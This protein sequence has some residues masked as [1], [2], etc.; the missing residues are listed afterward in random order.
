MKT[1]SSSQTKII[2][3]LSTCEKNKTLNKNTV[4][5]KKLKKSKKSFTNFSEEMNGPKNTSG[6]ISTAEDAPSSYSHRK[7][8]RPRR[9]AAIIANDNLIA[10]QADDVLQSS[11]GH[12]GKRTAGF[13]SSPIYAVK[14]KKKRKKGA[15]EDPKDEQ[16]SANYPASHR[17]KR[18]S[19]GTKTSSSEAKFSVA[20]RAGNVSTSRR[21]A[22][23]HFSNQVS[24]L[25]LY[26]LDENTDGFVSVAR[27]RS[28]TVKKKDQSQTIPMLNGDK[29]RKSNI[30]LSLSPSSDKEEFSPVQAFTQNENSNNDLNDWKER[31]KRAWDNLLIIFRQTSLS[32]NE[33]KE[34]PAT[35][36]SSPPPEAN[37]I[38]SILHEISQVD[39]HGLQWA[40]RFG[41]LLSYRANH[42]HAEV[43]RDYRGRLGSW[44]HCQRNHRESMDNKR[45]I[46]LDAIG[47]RWFGETNELDASITVMDPCYAEVSAAANVIKPPKAEGS[48]LGFK[49]DRKKIRKALT[50]L[51]KE[52]RGA[53]SPAGLLA[54]NTKWEEKY[55]ILHDYVAEH[56]H[57]YVPLREPAG[58]LGQWVADQRRSMAS[59]AGKSKCKERRSPLTPARILAL[60]SLGFWWGRMVD[61]NDVKLVL[62]QLSTHRKRK[63]GWEDIT[64]GV[65]EDAIKVAMEDLKLEATENGNV[66]NGEMGFHSR[67]VA[68]FHQ[69]LEFLREH[70]HTLVPGKHPGGLGQWVSDQRKYIATAARYKGDISGLKTPLTPAR[71]GALGAAKFWWGM[72]VDADDVDAVLEML[73]KRGRFRGKC[74]EEKCDY[75]PEDL[76]TALANLRGDTEKKEGRRGVSNYNAGKWE[77]KFQLLVKYVHLHNHTHVPGRYPGGLGQWA[78]DQ[79]KFMVTLVALERKRSKLKSPL[80]LLR[81]KT[82]EAIKFWWGMSVAAKDV[83]RVIEGLQKCAPDK[84]DS[85]ENVTTC[86]IGESEAEVGPTPLH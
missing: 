78:A 84:L 58:G 21:S 60:E 19:K 30:L 45:R 68:K 38:I 53:G 46:C 54:R 31:E 74:L 82:L 86:V 67:W 44:V 47:F 57:A 41:A 70:G 64:R 36:D 79:R 32:D 17:T 73:C 85:L 8:G 65:D 56:G 1:R 28:S 40:C 9:H 72:S 5:E 43:P 29:T 26:A 12:I 14:P 51:R 25:P 61:A 48:T 39:M 35:G 62:E 59:S 24:P 42:G 81:I 34:A 23:Y 11:V 52:G 16:G 77:K 33:G 69:L 10:I 2:I 3:Q 66:E 76:N 7:D 55:F 4:P 20:D 50:A 71:I 49:L 18:G 27:H 75:D 80:T 6:L 63:D 37:T 83:K 15:A 22:R 13:L